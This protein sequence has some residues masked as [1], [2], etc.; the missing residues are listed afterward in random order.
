MTWRA[1][2]ITGAIVASCVLASCGPPAG[3]SS[4]PAVWHELAERA[5]RRGDR[6]ARNADA[7]ADGGMTADVASLRRDAV[8]AWREAGRCY[9]NVFR[10][11]DPRASLRGPR[12][13]MAFRTARSFSK[14]ARALPADAASDD[15]A[16]GALFWFAHA[17]VLE[18]SSRQAHYERARL[19]D[20]QIAGARDL[21]RAR[22]GYERYLAAYDAAKTPV[23]GEAERAA[24]ARARIEALRV[25]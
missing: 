16:G 22:A 10:L 23:A 24:H 2:W 12:A 1:R 7:R 20:S 13:Q 8:A 3:P 9:R 21:E 18:P 25:R 5:F 15:L 14:A 17:L 6:S 19:F 4:D 11:T